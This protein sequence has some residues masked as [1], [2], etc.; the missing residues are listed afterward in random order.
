MESVAEEAR[1]DKGL[2]KS[3]KRR[4][5]ERLGEEQ[6][7]LFFLI[8]KCRGGVVGDVEF[9]IGKIFFC[10]ILLKVFA[11]FW[12]LFAGISSSQISDIANLRGNKPQRRKPRKGSARS[13]E[14]L[15]AYA[16]KELEEMEEYLDLEE[17]EQVLEHLEAKEC[18]EAEEAE[19]E[20]ME[21]EEREAEEREMEEREQVLFSDT[22]DWQ[23]ELQSE[24]REPQSESGEPQS[25]S[26]EAH[27]ESVTQ[28]DLVTISPESGA[29]DMEKM[30]S[31]DLTKKG[32]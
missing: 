9:V 30:D 12:G 29:S 21:A 4:R 7:N 20:Q 32:L 16:F 1:L 19:K 15:K 31:L 25:E 28:S 18:K 14:S 10:V 27:S 5:G 3:Q 26:E 24:S 22:D 6:S 13:Y 8:L 11:Y 2:N 17:L 23:E